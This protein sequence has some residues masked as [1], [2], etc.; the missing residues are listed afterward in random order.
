MAKKKRRGARFVS[1]QPDEETLTEE[2]ES[3]ESEETEDADDESAESE[4]EEDSDGDESDDTEAL[5]KEEVKVKLAS[6]KQFVGKVIANIVEQTQ[7]LFSIG[8]TLVAAC[9]NGEKGTDSL[10]RI[11]PTEHAADLAQ[12]LYDELE[13]E[14]Q[15][16]QTVKDI[17][18]NGYDFVIDTDW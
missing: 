1:E 6:P 10:V 5:E 9:D 7:V 18:K 16:P 2:T 11:L 17:A 4:T 3:E 12:F 13:G 8:G 14:G 15:D